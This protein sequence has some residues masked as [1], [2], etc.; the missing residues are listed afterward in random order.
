VWH[1]DQG[2]HLRATSMARQ[3][4]RGAIVVRGGVLRDVKPFRP[5]GPGP[6]QDAFLESPDNRS[7]N[8]DFATGGGMVGVDFNANGDRSVL[9][10]MLEIG[11][12]EPKFE[13]GRIF[14]GHNGAHPNANPFEFP[15]TPGQGDPRAIS[16]A[17]AKAAWDALVTQ[18]G[19]PAPT[20]SECFR[21]GLDDPRPAFAWT[22]SQ[23]MDGALD[24]GILTGSSQEFERAAVQLRRHRL[25]RAGTI[26]Y[27]PG[28]DPTPQNGRWWDDNASLAI[29]LLQAYEQL[30]N[31]DDLR[32]VQDLWPFFEAGH[33][34][35]GGEAENEEVPFSLRGIPSTAWS[36]E[37]A[38]LLYLD[39]D[40][41]KNDLV[42]NRYKTFASDNDAWLKKNLATKLHL[43]YQ[44]WIDDPTQSHWYDKQSRRACPPERADMP[45]LTPLQ[46]LPSPPP[47][48]VCTWVSVHTQGLMIGSDL[49]FYRVM[50]DGS[51]LKSAVEAA[52]ATLDYY[53]PDWLWKQS[54]ATLVVFFRNLMALDAVAPHPRYREALRAYLD[55]VWNEGRDPETGFFTKGGMAQYSNKSGN[56]LDQ[57]S[58]IQMFAVFAWPQDKLRLLH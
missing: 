45:P 7:I 47:P 36:D 51:Y 46:P 4:F 22:L 11:E 56:A 24:L 23:I 16:A 18:V 33:N 1:D 48:Q 31:P 53:T 13:P 35:H 2:W 20:C 8:F 58:L 30:H 26:G 55:R 54:P 27:A 40:T 21:N 44:S 9:E 3:H 12:D 37:V 15:G 5:A 28:I 34:P 42:R 41:P 14:I 29:P 43:Y 38:L 52:D 17:R 10:F 6:Q 32:L 25:E 19:S 39:S 49:L 57:A 50:Q